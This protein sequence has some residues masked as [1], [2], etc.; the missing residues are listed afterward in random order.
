MPILLGTPAAA[1][2]DQFENHC[3]KQLIPFP[4]CFDSENYYNSLVFKI[5]LSSNPPLLAI[6]IRPDRAISGPGASKGAVESS[7]L[8]S[9]NTEDEGHLFHPEPVQL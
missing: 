4:N 6:G 8:A 9:A 7:C 2:K 3:S 5:L 1:V